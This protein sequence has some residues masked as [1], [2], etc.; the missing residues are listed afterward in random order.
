MS[1]ENKSN[2]S[3]K[4][5]TQGGGFAAMSLTDKLQLL[6]VIVGL[7]GVVVAVYFG[8]LSLRVAGNPNAV[9][10]IPT[11]LTP[12]QTATA[13]VPGTVV[14]EDDFENG[15]EK[16][17][18]GQAWEI[19]DDGK[20]NHY[21]CATP[22]GQGIGYSMINPRTTTGAWGD[23]IFSVRVMA[24]EPLPDTGF[25]LD[26]HHTS[27]PHMLG[28]QFQVTDSRVNLWRFDPESN[29]WQRLT[30]VD[31][32]ALTPGTWYEVQV[33]VKSGGAIL[34]SINDETLIEFTDSTAFVPEGVIRIGASP[35]SNVC[36]DD[37]RVSVPE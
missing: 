23:Y 3:D 22:K 10:A 13:A 4:R 5:G 28:Y 21:A 14:L 36:V 29:K 35:N 11:S 30:A 6:G 12:V 34:Y 25:A 2:K 1:E 19:R 24:V 27:M 9:T 8:Y 33:E 31:S 37:V 15:L 18:T 26:V 7:I 20:G 17:K 16:W 32:Q